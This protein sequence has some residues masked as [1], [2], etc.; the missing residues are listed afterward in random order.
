MK[1]ARESATTLK[2]PHKVTQTIDNPADSLIFDRTILCGECVSRC[3]VCGDQFT[4]VQGVYT[5]LGTDESDGLYRGSHLVARESGHRRD[6]VA[7]RTQGET[8]GHRWDLVL[9]QHKGQT[10]V[11]IDVLEAIS[12]DEPGLAVPAARRY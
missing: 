10:L 3:P 9:Q 1:T 8:C 11:R 2:Y 6:A 7:V 5:L 4:H 12:P